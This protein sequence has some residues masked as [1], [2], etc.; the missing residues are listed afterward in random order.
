[1][2]PEGF[3]FHHFHI[4]NNIPDKMQCDERF[5]DAE[6][7]TTQCQVVFSETEV[8]D[9]HTLGCRATNSATRR[10][11]ESYLTLPTCGSLDSRSLV[12]YTVHYLP[13]A[14][15]IVGRLSVIQY[16]TALWQL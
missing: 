14:A 6:G 8:E 2:L 11:Q 16:A 3:P 7:R 10:V 4:I 15:L 9:Y 12:S 13:V 5:E 1:M